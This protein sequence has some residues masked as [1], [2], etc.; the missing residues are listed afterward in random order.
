V[1]PVGPWDPWNRL[2]QSPSSPSQP[3]MPMAASA[4][5]AINGTRDRVMPRALASFIVPLLTRS[6]G[7]L[8]V[9]S[10]SS[11]WLESGCV[12]YCGAGLNLGYPHFRNHFDAVVA[13]SP[14]S[15]LTGLDARTC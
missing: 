11:A 5:S 3:A 14:Q 8:H 4:I 12:V 1:G 10:L 15:G 7:S 13:A 6:I 2:G 9:S